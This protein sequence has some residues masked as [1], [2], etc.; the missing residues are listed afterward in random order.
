MRTIKEVE[1]KQAILHK[2]DNSKESPTLSDFTLE[3][4]EEIL[5]FINAHILRS[6]QDVG[7]RAAKYKAGKNII[8]ELVDD[9]LDKP[10]SFIDNSKDIAQHL[11]TSM[12]SN[13]K[14]SSADA[15]VC[16]YTGN[17]QNYLT[18]L[19]LDYQNNLFSETKIT[20]DGKVKNVIAN[21]GISLPNVKQK[22]QKCVFFKQSVAD[23]EYDMVLIDKQSRSEQEKIANFFANNFLCCNLADTD[24]TRTKKF[25]RAVRQWISGQVAV[26]DEKRFMDTMVNALKN[27]ASINVVEFANGLFND[28]EKSKQFLDFMVQHG[29]NDFEFKP[30]KNYVDTRLKKRHIKT[31]D[32]I[33]INI[34]NEDYQNQDKFEAKPIDGSTRYNICIKNVEVTKW[35]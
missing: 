9:T 34:S 31:I 2:L 27:Q 5:T 28:E 14:I 21:N 13:R 32:G 15:L 22:L 18:V 3:M 4:P 11:F 17:S 19:K 12:K 1:I 20:E 33:E 8:R 23:S 24:L 7:I 10:E 29:L 35:E 26:E 25:N 16:F 30:D 6:L